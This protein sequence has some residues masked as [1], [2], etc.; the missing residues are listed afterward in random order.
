MALRYRYTDAGAPALPANGNHDTIRYFLSILKACLV[1]GYGAKAGAGWTVAYED[2]T[3]DK[4]RLALSNGNGVVEFVTWDN[5]GLGIFIWDEIS[6]PGSGAIYT[7]P[8]NSVVSQGING[9]QRQGVA[10]GDEAQQVFCLLTFFFYSTYSQFHDWT[11]YADDKAAWIY[12]HYPDGNAQAEPGDTIGQSSSY[13]PKLFI[14][15]I[16]SADLTKDQQGNLFILSGNID[17][18]NA[19]PAS[20]NQSSLNY[21]WGLRTPFNVPPITTD[22]FGAD[23]WRLG[24]YT[25]NWYS[26]FRV[27]TPLVLKFE[28]AGVPLPTGMSTIYGDYHFGAVPGIIQLANDVSAADFWQHFSED[29][30]ATWSL[31]SHTFNGISMMP[32]DLGNML[33]AGGLTTDP[34]WWP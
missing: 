16:D 10:A 32:I 25:Q 5:G 26:S 14:G 15:A 18:P 3:A 29:N 28:G 17:H 19:S 24:N 9:W 7:D 4:E 8:F 12:F 34:A 21:V 6:N 20:N 27:L 13:H 31:E 22:E 30:S 11:V 1:D 2:L 33:A 23:S